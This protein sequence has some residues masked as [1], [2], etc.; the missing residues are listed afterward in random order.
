MCV[1]TYF[2]GNL[3]SIILEMIHSLSLF[4]KIKCLI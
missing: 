1:Y 3:N 4:A 2:A